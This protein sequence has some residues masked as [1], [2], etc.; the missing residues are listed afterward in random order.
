MEIIFKNFYSKHRSIL[1]NFTWRF[2]QIFGK[3]GILYFIFFLCA[4]L[5]DSYNFGIYNYILAIVFFLI[6]F[7]DFGISTASSK[8]VAEYNITSQEKLKAVVFNAGLIILILA[9]VITVLTLIIGPWYLGEKY[10]YTLWLMPLVF[11]APMT[12]LLDGVYRGLR[13]FKELAIISL[14]AGGIS[15][16]IAYFLVKSH[17]LMGA[18]I[19]QDFF[20]LILL[21]GLTIGCGGFH[22]KINKNVIKDIG[23]YSLTYGIAILGNY[24]FI[25][26]GILILGH[27]QYI[28]EIGTYEL[29]NKIFSILLLPFSLLGQ[30]IAPNFSEFAVRGEYKKIFHKA[31]KYTIYFFAIG[32]VSGLLF[33]F[34][35]PPLIKL[36]F[37]NYY[38]NAFVNMFPF[39][40]LIFITNVWANTID[41]GILVPAGFANVMAKFYI[42]LGVFGTML[43]LFFVRISGYMGVVYSFAICSFLMVVL[44]RI[45]FLKRLSK[46]L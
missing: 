23:V 29:L 11:L 6:M 35:I 46:K 12:S 24:L 19:A 31:K 1:I 20:Y 40:V 26:F 37:T 30:V 38:D 27:Y 13:K 4:K 3:Q 18:I 43:S 34:A 25:R 16:F 17:G 39:V 42:I 9:C 44:L 41:A 36:F 10:I 22:F 28:T 15:I 45:M 14:S 8:F 7:G 21:L 5:L 2:L 32:I 33:Y